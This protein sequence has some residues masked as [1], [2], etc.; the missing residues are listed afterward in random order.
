MSKQILGI[1]IRQDSVSAILVKSGIKGNWIE[2]HVHVPLSGQT[3]PPDALT[4]TEDPE[5]AE[6]AETEEV[7]SPIAAALE[8]IFEMIDASGASCI[9]SIPA[10]EVS[11]RNIQIP[12]KDQKK[13]DRFFLLN[14]KPCCLFPQRT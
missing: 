6:I 14:W 12:F 5:K 8:K 13:S 2:S 4:R 10:D 1:D 11:Y 3:P 9:V 7:P